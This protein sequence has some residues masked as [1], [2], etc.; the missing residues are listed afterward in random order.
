MAVLAPCWISGPRIIPPLVPLYLG[1][2]QV[3]VVDN[4]PKVFRLAIGGREESVSVDRLKPHLGTA[5]VL[6]QLLLLRGRPPSRGVQSCPS[7]ST[8]AGGN[9]VATAAARNR[10]DDM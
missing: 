10:G 8:L 7:G 1:P 6:P 3:Q 9:V 2:Y 4:G 5:G